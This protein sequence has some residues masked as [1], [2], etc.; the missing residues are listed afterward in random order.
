MHVKNEVHTERFNKNSLKFDLQ[1]PQRRI[2]ERPVMELQP[3]SMALVPFNGSPSPRAVST[4]L[5]A[6]GNSQTKASAMQL[7]LLA[8]A[9]H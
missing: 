7:A 3:T 4:D 9:G 5:P 6:L 1:P 2:D 8:P